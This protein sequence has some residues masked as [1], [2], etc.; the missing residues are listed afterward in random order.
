MLNIITSLFGK[1]RHRMPGLA[2]FEKKISSQFGEDGII[3]AIFNAIPPRSRYFVEFGIGPNSQDGD[4]KN[5]LEGNCVELRRQ[6]WRGLFMDSGKHPEFTE[7]KTE[8]IT[9]DNINS[10][11]D[12]HHV[13]DDVDVISIDVDGQD[14]WIWERITH[15]PI[16]FILE[17]N[18][19]KLQKE[20][21]TVPL[22]PAFKWDGTDYYGASL[23]ALNNL[24]I[25]KNYTLVFANGVNAFFVRSD[26]LANRRDFK[27]DCLFRPAANHP[28][29]PQRR[30]FVQ[31]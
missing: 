30:T 27:F 1:K 28:R 7:I 22:N 5:G 2:P 12:K 23:L 18:G 31:V 14:W 3:E 17:Y 9:S 13:P 24:A 25:K 29:D 16:L 21:V 26:L 4:Y 8:F 11:L 19:H 20:S 10:L 15:Q 6:G